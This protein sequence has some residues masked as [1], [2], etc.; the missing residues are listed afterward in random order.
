M[1]DKNRKNTISTRNSGRTYAIIY[2]MV[3]TFVISYVHVTES[4][5]TVTLVLLDTSHL[6]YKQQY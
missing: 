2:L 4:H 6:V 5:H 1:R 3:N